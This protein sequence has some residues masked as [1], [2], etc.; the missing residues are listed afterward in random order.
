MVKIFSGGDKI[1]SGGVLNFSGGVKIFWE[2]LRFFR[3]S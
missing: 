1:F 3:R 2:V